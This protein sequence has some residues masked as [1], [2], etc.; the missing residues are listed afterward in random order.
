[1]KVLRDRAEKCRRGAKGHFRTAGRAMALRSFSVVGDALDFSTRR[2][3]TVMRVTALPLILLLVFNMAA[4]LGYLSVANGRIITFTDIANAGATWPQVVQL[5]SNALSSGIAA[6]STPVYLIFTASSLLNVIIVST[7]MAP[8]IRY[9]GLGEK[10]APGLVRAPFG[11]DQIRFLLSGLLSFLLTSLVVYGPIGFATFVIIGIIS[12]AV[13]APGARFPD[14]NSLHTVDLVSGWEVKSA[15]ADYW[16]YQYGYWSAATAVV[17]GLLAIVFILHFRPRAEDRTAGIGL[18]WRAAGV[19]AF[20]AL[21]F[22]AAWRAIGF[23]GAASGGAASPD[24]SAAGI[25]GAAALLAAIFL[26]LRLYPYTGVAVCRRS[27]GFAGTFRAT[28]R[29]S[30][31]TL[32]LAFVLLG[33]ILFLAQLLLVWVG[34]GA[35]WAVTAY[36]AA[37]VESVVRLGSDGEGG[38]WVMPFFTGLWAFIGIVFTILWTAFTYGVSAGL[39]GRLYRESL[40]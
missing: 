34:G 9:A 12:K 40:N 37:A 16:L 13:G 2:F 28:R 32:G 22:A 29:Y 20:L 33:L 24:F 6:G 21:Y 26:G 25:F 30:I 8:L 4:A 36:I 39:W 27:L 23:F 18:F 35:A 17:A 7:F 14:E 5:A 31:L 11:P 3:E 1:M 10:P 38:N 19:L 15:H